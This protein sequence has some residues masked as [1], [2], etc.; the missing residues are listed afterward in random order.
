[1]YPNWFGYVSKCLVSIVKYRK[2]LCTCPERS[3]LRLT[4]VQERIFAV[5]PCVVPRFRLLWAFNFFYSK[6]KEI[7]GT[8]TGIPLFERY[9][10]AA[11][12]Q[13]CREIILLLHWREIALTVWAILKEEQKLGAR[14]GIPKNCLPKFRAKFG[15]TFWGEFLLKP[16]ILWIKG[17]NRSDNSW[18]GFGWFFA[19]ERLLRSPKNS[20]L[21]GR[22]NF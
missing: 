9:L 17:P 20:F 13:N 14:K 1:M 22:G 18:E 2:T 6:Q 21:W 11:R 10:H 15:W 8:P 7:P 4:H 19:I 12:Q 3:P 5:P 16:F